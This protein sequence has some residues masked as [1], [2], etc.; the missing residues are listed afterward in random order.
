MKRVAAL[1]VGVLVIAVGFEAAAACSSGEERCWGKRI[2]VCTGGAWTT[3]DTCPNR[4]AE[5]AG[6]AFCTCEGG[7]YVG[8]V[9]LDDVADMEDFLIAGYQAV[10]GN[11]TVE[12]TTATDLYTLL[13]LEQV[14]GDLFIQ[15]NSDLLNANIPYLQYVGGDFGIGFN[16]NLELIKGFNYLVQVDGLFDIGFN[17]ALE[18]IKGFKHLDN[19][20]RLALSNNSSLIDVYGFDNLVHLEH[21]MLGGSP[22][23]KDFP[24]SS[25]ITELGIF[26]L[27]GLA[28]E[29]LTT[30]SNLTH[31]THF[32]LGNMEHITHLN[33]I[34]GLNQ[35]DTQ[36]TIFYND[37]L[38]FCRACAFYENLVAPPSWIIQIQ[39]NKDDACGSGETCYCIE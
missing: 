30:F 12:G 16:S 28:F 22:H 17:G 6:D 3:I 4:C 14:S 8:D 21:L 19:L 23:L 36:L 2:Q 9:M 29:D 10:Q 20:W 25:E 32:T 24:F 34:S 26:S 39:F 5:L 1:I 31:V 33:D 27:T 37:N 13:C 35:V 7:V 11:L 18:K 15:Y 38:P